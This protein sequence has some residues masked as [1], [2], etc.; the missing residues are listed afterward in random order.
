M[1][2]FE[3]Q[4]PEYE[5]ATNLFGCPSYLRDVP[6][7]PTSVVSD[8]G[9]REMQEEGKAWLG[10]H[11][12]EDVEEL[13]MMKQHHVHVRNPETNKRDLLPA[14]RSKENPN[15]CKGNFPMNKWLVDDTVVLCARLLRDMGLHV[16]GRRCQLGSLHGPMLHESINATHSAML[17]GQRCNSD[18]QLPN[19][20]PIIPQTHRCDSPACLQYSEKMMVEATQIAQ[21]AQAGYACDYCSKRQPMAFN[22]CKEACKGHRKLA[23]KI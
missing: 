10:K 7:D 18:V 16:R 5:T 9:M 12:R 15:L 17:A 21:D 23:E 13:Q 11:L 14:S 8:E 19:R 2:T 4:W 22:E 1:N 20:F 6:Y 3:S